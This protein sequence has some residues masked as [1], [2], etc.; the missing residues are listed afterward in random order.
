MNQ[1]EAK[2]A[3]ESSAKNPATE[4]NVALKKATKPGTLAGLKQSDV[5]SVLGSM[6]LSIEA[7]LPKH[8]NA[9]R[10]I[11]MA[12]TLIHRNPKIAECTAPSLVGAVMQAS[13][14]GFPPVE[15]LGYCYFVPYKNNV[16]F[17]MGYRGMIDLA[18]R[19]GQ[20]KTIY[21]EVVREGDAFEYELGL[22]PKLE[23]KPVGDPSKRVTKVYAVAHY[24]DGG[25][26]FVVLDRMDIERLRL[27]SPM[28]GANP[29]G[30]WLTDYDAMAKAKAI[31]QLA[32]YLP[33]NIDFVSA[34]ATDTAIIKPENFVEG[35]VNLNSVD[36]A[37]VVE[38]VASNT[39][40]S[41][42]PG[43]SKTD[44]VEPQTTESQ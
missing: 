26:N 43:A 40:D 20:I 14:L 42:L 9:E 23:H 39:G 7:A 5:A 33:L 29:S 19:S 10:M 21:A 27:R 12:A 34:M 41:I 25:N 16:Q 31:K 2:S 1:N 4:A 44:S 11:Q 30:P 17:Q 24:T 8:L 28:Q 32:K 38:D 6:K 36:Y 22:F 35:Q 13:I 15:S 18:R 3:M 37:E